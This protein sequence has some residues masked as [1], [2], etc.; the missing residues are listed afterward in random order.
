MNLFNKKYHIQVHMGKLP[1]KK[2][3][4][5]TWGAKGVLWKQR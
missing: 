1:L 4:K 5:K 2:K 3:K